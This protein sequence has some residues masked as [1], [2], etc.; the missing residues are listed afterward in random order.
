MTNGG[1]TPSIVIAGTFEFSPG[2]ARTFAPLH[3][4]RDGANDF[5]FCAELN[6]DH[7]QVRFRIATEDIERIANTPATRGA[8]LVGRLIA[9]LGEGPD[10]R[11]SEQV[12]DFQVFVS[13]EGETWI[14]S[15]G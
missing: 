13:D 12:N 3:A 9:W 1:P 10:N 7:K 8:R 5:W 4:E 6:P 15:L 11:L 2:E 14:E